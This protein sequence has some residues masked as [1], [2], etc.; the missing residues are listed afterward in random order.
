M[1][2]LCIRICHVC[3]HFLFLILYVLV[4]MQN[5]RSSDILWRLARAHMH[6][7]LFCKARGETE[8]EKDSLMTGDFFALLIH[9]FCLIR[10]VPS[11]VEVCLSDSMLKWG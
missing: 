1:M 3:L 6:K 5:S 2:L 10:C 8:A 4:H 11:C 7:S 9:T